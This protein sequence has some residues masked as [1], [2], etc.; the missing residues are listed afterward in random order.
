MEFEN[1]T[2]GKLIASKNSP[3]V[4]TAAPS[5]VIKTTTGRIPLLA[6]VKLGGED[7]MY[8]ALLKPKD[9]L[10]VF[11]TAAQMNIPFLPR[12]RSNTTALKVR[13]PSWS[14]RLMEAISAITQH[15][16]IWAK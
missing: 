1:E 12:F 8:W 5:N 11:Q 16:N 3:H 4:G 10:C 6:V 13:D 7:V 15:G 2:H 14:E 9:G